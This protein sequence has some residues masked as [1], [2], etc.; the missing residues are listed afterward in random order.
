MQYLALCFQTKSKIRLN[1]LTLTILQ[2]V[3][4]TSLL[5]QTLLFFRLKY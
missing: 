5:Q 4:Q 1:K 2:K 3:V